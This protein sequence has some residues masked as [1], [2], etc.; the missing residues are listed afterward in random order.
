VCL[1]VLAC[2][3]QTP[4]PPD[5]GPVTVHYL[6]HD[7]PP[8]VQ[9][10]EAAFNDYRATHRSVNIVAETIRYPT[11][12]TSLLA[13]LAADTLFVDLVRMPP[14]WVCGFAA[15]LADVPADVITLQEAEKVFFPAPLAGS[16]CEGKLKGLP[17]EYNL[18]YGGVVVNLDKFQARFPGRTPGWTDWASFI[19]DAAALTEY[20]A[21][22]R[23]AANGLDIAPDWPQPVKHIFFSQILQRGGQYWAPGGKTFDFDTPEARESLQEMVAWVNRDKVM[24]PSLIP[25]QNT[26]VTTRL[27]GGATGYGWNDPSRPLSVMGYAGTWAVPNTI[28]QLPAGKHTHYGY[29]TLPPM[30]GTQHRFV[31]NSGFALVVPRTSKNPRAAW[32]LARFVTLSAEA[33]RR[34]SSIGGALPALR[35][36]G[37]TGA[38]AG[39]PTLAKVQ[40]LLERG[41]W[42][43]YIPAVAIE[44]VEGVI[45][46]N[47]FDAVMGRKTVPEALAEMERTANAALAQTR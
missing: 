16:V 3:G 44:V 37:T 47:Y 13:D 43:G 31:Q 15:N 10:D 40:P 33:A 35:D 1:V 2:S 4:P 8:Y 6:R 17:I 28:A 34:W 9:A 20:D 5:D 36:N 19:A 45:V 27:V 11:L 42:I 24:F 21:A 12:T 32:D 23:P 41:Q 26:F 29:F 38:V 22:G 18:E 30:V 25:E 39:D 14:S 7:N 46:S